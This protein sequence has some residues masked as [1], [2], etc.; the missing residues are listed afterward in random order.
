MN[1]QFVDAAGRVTRATD[2]L[3]RATR[4]V[5]DKLNRV[6]AVTNPIGGQ[7]SLTYDANSNLL[8]LTDALIHATTYTY[9]TSDRVATRTD[10]LS[11]AASYQYDLNG[12]RT[13]TTDRKSQVTASTY[14]ALDRLTQVTFADS[15]TIS[16]TYDAGDRLTQM[17]DS[18]NGTIARTHDGLDRL[19]QETTPQGTVDYTYDT[20]GRRSTMTVAGQTAVI[21]AYDNANRLSSITQGAAVVAVTYDDANRRST[22]TY[23]NGIVATYGYDD[24]NQLTSLAYT[25]SGTPIGDLTYTYDVAGNRTA[26]GGSWARTGLPPALTTATYDAANRLTAWSGTSF[27]YD[28]NGNLTNDGTKTYDWNA[29]NQLAAL[30]GGV[31]ASFAYDGVGRR[32]GKTISGTTTNFLYDGLTFVQELSSGGTPTANLLT[33]LG[34]D[35]AF[36]RSDGGGARTLLTDA[37]G[38]TLALANNSGSV[39]TTYTFEPFGAA[40]TSGTASTNTG[41]FA[42]REND[43]TGLYFYR[44]RFYHPQLQRFIAPDPIGLDGGDVNLY[45][46]V[47]NR[48]VTG[49]DPL[50][51]DVLN[52]DPTKP[53]AVKPENGPWSKLPPCS[54]WPG[55][56][57]GT[58]NPGASNGAPWYK[59]HGWWFTPPN[60]IVIPPGNG[61]PICV[62][63]T[64][65][66]PWP[67]GGVRTLLKEPDDTWIPGSDLSDLPDLKP[68]RPIP[69]C[70]KT[71]SES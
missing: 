64:C 8:S 22:L 16:Y 5:I 40:T 2:P 27:S 68:I 49:T 23:P 14:D 61:P 45:S 18:S 20:A 4:T 70:K 71:K 19:T 35:E 1:S 52:F 25:L 67:I 43:G 31:N 56:P 3:G 15:S 38:S 10:P 34:I 13:Q 36:T 58:L 65:A 28:M 11:H 21:Y 37:L 55:S 60:V 24:A 33:G 30:S 50:G 39:Q 46:Y 62:A 59:V 41:Q 12:N 66:Y 48:P 53:T 57:D 47:T 51:L 29:R 9:D 17:V 63:G 42:G 54:R 69:G 7:T 44:A 26:V 32:R 6:T